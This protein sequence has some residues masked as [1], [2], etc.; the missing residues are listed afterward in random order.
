MKT[1]F[2]ALALA[3]SPAAFAEGG[4]GGDAGGAGGNAPAQQQQ[5]APVA[6]REE[7][8][9]PYD[10]FVE[11]LEE[12]NQ[13]RDKAAKYD[14]LQTRYTE[15]QGKYDA[16]ETRFREDLALAKTGLD[17]EGLEVA[18]FLHGRLPEKDRPAL[19]DWLKSFDGDK[20]PAPTALRGYLDASAG[21]GQQQTVVDPNTN[22]VVTAP[23]SGDPLSV[24]QIRAMRE[25]AQSSGD[26]TEYD[27]HRPAILASINGGAQQ[28]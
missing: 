2:L 4:G 1:L 9:I 10:R 14:E 12:R 13:F 27:K 20:N 8:V 16:Q 25:R 21:A 11:V 6:R 26:W 5:Q 23:P 22:T 3:L 19:A 7:K 24:E 28:T 15:L 18:R 17:E